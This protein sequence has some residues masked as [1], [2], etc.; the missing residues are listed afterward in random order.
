[1]AERSL[2]PSESCASCP[3]NQRT[4]WRTGGAMGVALA[5]TLFGYLLAS[6]GLSRRANGRTGEL[7]CRS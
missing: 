4:T 7:A 1:M 3:W 6:A 2:R 5:A